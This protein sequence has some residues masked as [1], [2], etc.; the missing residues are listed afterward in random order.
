LLAD[1]FRMDCDALVEGL[2]AAYPG[3]PVM[4]GLASGDPRVQRSHVFL[5]D[6][7]FSEGGVALAVGGA[8]TV[9]TVVAEGATPIGEAWTVTAAEANVIGAIGRRPAYE[10][11]METL[12]ALPEALRRRA[13]QNLLV[14]LAIN[15]YR[16]SFGRGDF[17]IRNL[18]GADRQSGALAIGAL[19]RVGQTMQ[20]QIR[21]AESADQDLREL[22]AAAKRQ[23]G[24]RQPLAALLCACN[25]RGRGLFGAPDH[26]ARAVAELLG[27]LPLAGFF[28]NGE[29]GP[30]GGANHLHGYTASLA[31]LAPVD[32]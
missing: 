18:L 28:C 29:I 32:V 8:L 13:Q 7:V 20:F 4:G 6:Q 10:L 9:E 12:M 2:S 23:L 25:G 24:E 16:D 26:D 1:P 14:G 22:L 17:L 21:D 30:V 31:L 3:L 5:N 19:P 11:L 15:E 27:P